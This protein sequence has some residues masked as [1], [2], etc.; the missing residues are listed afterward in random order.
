[1]RKAPKVIFQPLELYN[2]VELFYRRKTTVALIAAFYN[3]HARD[4]VRLSQDR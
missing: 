1:M 4:R 3:H 2:L